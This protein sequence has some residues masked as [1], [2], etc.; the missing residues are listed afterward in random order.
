[1]PPSVLL[2]FLLV[3]MKSKSRKLI[4][5]MIGISNVIQLASMYTGDT[6]DSKPSVTSK[7]KIFDP[8]VSLTTTLSIFF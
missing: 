7:V 6:I 3:T 1:M 5:T 4:K 2:S 8:S